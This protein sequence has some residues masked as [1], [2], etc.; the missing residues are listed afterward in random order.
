VCHYC[1]W[2]FKKH[3]ECRPDGKNRDICPPRHFTA[4]PHK[5]YRN[6]GDGTFTDVSKEA[7]LRTDGRG[8]GVVV[9]DLDGDGKPD[10]FV[11]ND[12]DDNFLYLNRSTPGKLRLEE[13]GLQAGV[14]RDDR[15]ATT[16]N[17]G[18]A[19]GD[20]D[21]S[22]RPSILVTTYALEHLSLFRNQSRAG[23]PR[24][25]YASI[26]AGLSRIQRNSCSWGAGFFDVELDGRLDLFI[27]NGHVF[28]HPADK[29]RVAARPSLLRN[30]G[31]KFT[32]L[33]D[34]GGTYF[35]KDHRGRGVA[36]GDLD[37]DGRVDL[38]VSHLNEPVALLRNEVK[39]GQKHWL[40]IELRGKDRRSVVGARVT[41][42]VDGLS[43]QTRQVVGGGSF[44]SSGDPRLLFGLGTATRTGKLTVRW[45]NGAEQSWDG[46]KV[47]RYHVLVEG[48]A[49]RP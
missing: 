4:Q 15:G 22:G 10:I 14:A 28:R 34:R 42:E 20:Y 41:L 47:D 35:Q 18:V 17:N 21:N 33:G 7:G 37:N 5:L 45:P 25:R 38:V 9:V 43:M 46:L 1:D 6:R 23:G 19:V 32:S 36:L 49:K 8:L 48:A 26:A 13:L 11:A 29:T 31:G 16:G 2:S 39:V 27:A 30:D 24:F 3:P 44:A 12:T 40:G